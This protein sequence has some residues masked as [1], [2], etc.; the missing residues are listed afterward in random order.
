MLTLQ[1]IIDESDAL[2]PNSIPVADKIVYLNSVNADFFTEVKLPN[3][4]RSAAMAG[5]DTYQMPTDTRLKNIDYVQ[6]GPLLY[7]NAGRTKTPTFNSFTFDDSSQKI[8]LD[9]APYA[10]GVPIFVRYF[11]IATTTFVSS[12][13]TAQPDAPPEYHWTYIYALAAWLAHAMDDPVKAKN[14]EDQYRAAWASAAANQ[15]GA[16]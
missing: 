14:Y 15:Q 1:Q 2:T 7:D 11:R 9:P 8:T 5:T 16:K 6:V 13:L 10:A 3:F 4:W 12:V